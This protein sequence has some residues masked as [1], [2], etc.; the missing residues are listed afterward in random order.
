MVRQAMQLPKLNFQII[1]LTLRG[2]DYAHPLALIHLEFC[3]DYAPVIY[4]LKRSLT[5][6]IH[7][8]YFHPN[9]SVSSRRGSG[10]QTINFI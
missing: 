5:V 8:I 10:F 6:R 2:A 3:L 1:T 9:F 7:S 4:P